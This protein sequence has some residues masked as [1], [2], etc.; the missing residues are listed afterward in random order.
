MTG[1]PDWYPSA[2]VDEEPEAAG[3]TGSTF[4]LAGDLGNQVLDQVQKGRKLLVGLI[5]AA[6]LVVILA[7]LVGAAGATT[8][9][10][11]DQATQL[12]LFS[13]KAATAADKQLINEVTTC[14]KITGTILA[15]QWS[16]PPL[17]VSGDKLGTNPSL[18]TPNASGQSEVS[19]LA[20]ANLKLGATA[21]AQPAIAAHSGGSATSQARSFTE[22]YVSLMSS[23][24]AS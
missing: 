22:Q 10:H 23:V 20:A 11:G 9:I 4:G 12:G 13:G 14:G 8:V 5:T 2:R 6:M 18:T 3:K 15:V 1:L 21:Q 19:C 7:V 16:G 17:R 24:G